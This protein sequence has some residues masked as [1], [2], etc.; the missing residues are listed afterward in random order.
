M[1]GFFGRLEHSSFLHTER[2]DP[3][4]RKFSGLWSGKKKQQAFDTTIDLVL[5]LLF[6]L[7]WEWEAIHNAV[8][9]VLH[10][11]TISFLANLSL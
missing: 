3:I 9:V 8:A 2:I 11:V 1:F 10:L 5:S 7:E 4:M 6:I